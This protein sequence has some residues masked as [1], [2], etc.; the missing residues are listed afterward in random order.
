VIELI[1]LGLKGEAIGPANGQMELME[2]RPHG[3]VAA[4]VGTIRK[5]EL[6]RLLAT[7]SSR[8]KDLA[9]ALVAGRVIHPGSKLSL[10]RLC[11]PDSRVST[12]AQVLG[13]EGA[14]ENELYTAMDWLQERQ[15]KI[16][17]ALAARHLSDGCLVLYDV[18]SSYF[19]GRHCPLAQYG[20]SRDHRPDRLQITYGLLCNAEGCPVAIEVFEGKTGA[21][22][23]LPHQIQ[24]LKE[25]FHLERVVLVGDRGMITETRIEQ[26]LEPA[27]LDW[28][29]AL[30]GPAIE[31]LCAA[32]V[33]QPSLFDQRNIAEVTHPDFP[34]ERL[35]ACFNPFT[36]EERERQRGELLDATEE[37]L[38]KVHRTCIRKLKPLRGKGAI[39]IEVGKVLATHRMAKYFKVE[40][41]DDGFTFQRRHAL[42]ALEAAADGIYVIRTKVPVAQLSPENAQTSY[43]RLSR[44]ERAFRSLKGLDLQIRP[45]HHHLAGRVKAHVFLCMLAYYVEWHLRNA[46]EPLLFQGEPARIPNGKRATGRTQEG[47]P[48]MSYRD[49]L[50]ELAGYSRNLMR[51]IQAPMAT[52]VIHPKPSALQQRAFD[53]LGVSPAL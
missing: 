24:K 45:I 31:R 22:S 35:I 30:R 4:V 32:R 28:V 19:E 29:T 27:H 7:R 36:K 15:A 33:I 47:L 16:E 40:I 25:R 39:G 53:L 37:D 12:L 41:L 11:D 21:P 9:L 13:V 51:F 43:M 52:T 26:D 34:G 8:E 14:D 23:T 38:R 17:S 50:K 49:L 18:S 1:K 5:L 10:S 42:I 46:W 20:Y 6:D 44:V 48:V 2:A 3:H